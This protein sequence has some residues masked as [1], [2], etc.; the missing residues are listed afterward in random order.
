MSGCRI[1][2]ETNQLHDR[3]DALYEAQEVREAMR[4]ERMMAPIECAECAEKLR[5]GYMTNSN[6]IFCDSDCALVWAI[7]AIEQL[8]INKENCRE[9]R[10][11]LIEMNKRKD[12]S[13]EQ[14]QKGKAELQDKVD[15]LMLEYCPMK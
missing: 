4:E 6:G 12:A 13:I 5:S 14:L 10:D 8:E 11:E 2:H 1:K 9:S 15:S 3:E 7:D